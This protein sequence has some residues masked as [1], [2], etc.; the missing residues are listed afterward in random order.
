[1]YRTGIS[2]QPLVVIGLLICLSAGRVIAADD[3]AAAREVAAKWGGAVVTV[4]I[5]SKN[6]FSMPNMPSMNQQTTKSEATGTVVDPSG[7]TVV[8]LAELSPDDLVSSFMPSGTGISMSSDITDVK[9]R[10]PDGQDTP[11]QIVLRDKDFDLA[12]LR[13]AIKLAV[14]VVAVDL[15][16]SGIAA[17]ADR[18]V[19]LGRL[20]EVADRSVSVSLPTIS[21]VVDKPWH[22]Y[23][24]EGDP[25]GPVFGLDGR[26][27]GLSVLRIAPKAGGGNS[28]MSPFSMLGGTGSMPMIPI[29]LPAEQVA[30][31][32][33]QAPQSAP[34]PTAKP[35]AAT[36][37]KPAQ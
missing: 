36:P 19:D 31:I 30:R 33:A 4:T 15:T 35:S 25:N 2:V 9:I 32:A 3:A 1:M 34:T 6:G 22:F 14:P 20:G 7:L 27:I 37:S 23:V 29:I 26:I 10:Y 28:N 5:T 13:P 11:A 8:S 21:A 24:V 16:N 17:V 12:F 18:V